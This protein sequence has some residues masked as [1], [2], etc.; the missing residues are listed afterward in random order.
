MAVETSR[1]VALVVAPRPRS[2]RAATVCAVATLAVGAASSSLVLPTGAAL[3]IGILGFAGIVAGRASGPRL[4]AARMV[5]ASRRARAERRRARERELGTT[6]LGARESLAELTKLVDDIESTAPGVATRFELDDLLDR[7][8]ALALAHERSV[9]AVAMF[10]RGELERTREAL[11][12]DPAADRRRVELCE[13]R[14]HARAQCQVRVDQLA[15]ELA[16]LADLI[17][18]IAQQVACP[19][20][21]ALDD[22]IERHLAE[23]DEDDAVRKQLAED[24]A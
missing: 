2:G 20:E 4:R 5:R 16:L 11:R 14:L 10:D 23:L 6:T 21:P 9:R 15:N 17:R 18:L 7:H 1:A 8:V 13:R 22:R 24:L 3:V 12:D 19:E